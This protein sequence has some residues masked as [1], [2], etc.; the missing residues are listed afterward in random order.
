[1]YDAV[2]FRR[3][4]CLTPDPSGR[5][6][7]RPDQSVAVRD[8]RIVAMGDQEDAVRQALTGVPYSVYS[9]RGKLL[10]PA[11]AN[12]H[13]HIAM[14]LF[15]N[16]ADDRNLHDWLFQVIFPREAH[17]NESV[18]RAGTRLG[19]LEMIRSG[20]GAAA[21]MY[22]YHETIAEAAVEAGFRLNFS[23]DAK[24]TNP[25]GETIVQPRLMQDALRLAEQAP[26]QLLRASLLV[27]SV[28][29]YDQKLYPELAELAADLNC[30]VQVHVS[31]TA[32]EVDECLA[33]HGR[34]PPAQ[35]AEYGF[36]RTPTLAAHCVHLD[37]ADRRILAERDVTCVHN[38][39]SN[40]KLGSGFADVPALLNAG[41]R[42]GLGT[43]GAA[44]NNTLD[45]YRDM[46]LAALAA[47]GLHRDAAALPATDIL[48]MAT[49]DGMKGLG[50]TQSGRIEPGAAADLQVV[51]LDRPELTP[52]G[53][54]ASALVYCATGSCVESTMVAG[55]WLMKKRELMTLDEEKI[56]AE[57]RAASDWIN[58][59]A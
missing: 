50:F 30:P 22:Y 53:Q 16:Q 59:Q 55:R 37:D 46:H 10:L 39:A 52:L 21:D 3:I 35:L 41:I 29:L 25:A 23:C 42:V 8:G 43:D 40:L 13:G 18:V 6:L 58:A 12:L 51:D 27:H 33:L 48:R 2:F 54:P 9:G 19:L 49:L 56:L 28:Y 36:F 5:W 1:M 15:R 38:P 34:R 20:T 24:E 32:R 7:D 11:L 4:R 14:T 17:L 45:L 57:A 47:K 26:D 31:E 44:S